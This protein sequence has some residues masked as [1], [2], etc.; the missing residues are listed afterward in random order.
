MRYELSSNVECTYFPLHNHRSVE[1]LTVLDPSYLI[2][3]LLVYN[4]DL[5]FD[6]QI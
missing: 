6:K 2:K 3:Q 4:P 1:N 5:H